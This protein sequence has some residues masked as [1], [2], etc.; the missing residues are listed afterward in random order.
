M[1]NQINLL[2][3]SS[4]LF[5]ATVA[6][7][8]KV[9]PNEVKVITWVEASDLTFIPLVP[10]PAPVF[11]KLQPVI[12]AVLKVPVPDKSNNIPL[13]PLGPSKFP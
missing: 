7:D 5:S 3:S 4:S 9:P 13:A 12:V 2:S 1:L 8:A 11:S 10:P 6:S